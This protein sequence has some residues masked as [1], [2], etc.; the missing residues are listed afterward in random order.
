LRRRRDRRGRDQRDANIPV[1]EA[2]NEV[3]HVPLQTAVSMQRVHGTR[4]H[5]D[6]ELSNRERR[7]SVSGDL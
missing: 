4:E 6:A 2:S 7:H 5:G 3:V 1:Q